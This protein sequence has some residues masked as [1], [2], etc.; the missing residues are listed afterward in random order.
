MGLGGRAMI[1]LMP[2]TRERMRAFYRGFVYDPDIFT[3]M[4][5]F[6]RLKESP[7]N[8]EKVDALFDRRSREEDRV[9]FAVMLDG[10][11]IGEVGFKH[12][13]RERK[14]CELSINMQNDFVKNRGYGTEA[15]RQAVRY[16]FER[17]GMESVRAETVLKNAR[18]R[19][20]L[21]KLGFVPE[22]E[23]D[24]FRLYRLTRE[25]WDMG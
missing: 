5:L 6:E 23:R 24:G 2:M 22:G 11:V 10:R 4:E 15:E 3:D 21:E 9:F 19:H 8:E 25:D 16:A 14:D 20:V 7:Y 13:D 17:L 1:E 18:S 12:I